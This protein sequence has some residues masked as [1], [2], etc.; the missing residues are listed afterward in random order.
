MVQFYCCSYFFFH[1]SVAFYRNSQ[2]IKFFDLFDW[3]S[4][5]FYRSLFL[6]SLFSLPNNIVFVLLVFITILLKYFIV[7]KNAKK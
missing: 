1:P 6:L 5:N 4:I 2:I 3:F 7:L